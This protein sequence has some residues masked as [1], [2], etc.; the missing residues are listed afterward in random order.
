LT[1]IIFNDPGSRPVENARFAGRFFRL[2]SIGSS[3]ANSFFRKAE[4]ENRV[5]SVEQRARVFSFSALR[6]KEIPEL[7]KFGYRAHYSDSGGIRTPNQQNRNLSFYPVELRSREFS[8]K[9][10]KHVVDFRRFT[11]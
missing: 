9:D 11:Q 2:N 6:K 4:K 10:S 1:G 5:L 8:G 7:K 3:P